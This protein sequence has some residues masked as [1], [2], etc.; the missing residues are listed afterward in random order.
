M[1]FTE[2]NGLQLR[3]FRYDFRHYFVKTSTRTNNQIQQIMKFMPTRR[4]SKI[5]LLFSQIQD[6]KQEIHDGLLAG[7][8]GK[9]Q[10]D[11]YVHQISEYSEEHFERF[12]LDKE[13]LYDHI[14]LLLHNNDLSDEIIEVL[15]E[16]PKQKLIVLDK[17][18]DN[19]NGEYACVYQDF[20]ADL[21]VALEELKI[22]LSKYK[23]L[24]LLIPADEIIPVGIEKGF[25][26]FCQE[27]A[28]KQQIHYG[29]L[30][31]GVCSQE[32]YITVN[33]Q[34]LADLLKIA[35]QKKLKIGSDFGVISYQENPL[36]EVLLGG[37][38]S[39][40]SDSFQ[41]GKT[42]AELLINQRREHIRNPFVLIQ[43]NSL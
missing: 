8:H 31:Q 37:I 25:L 12:V 35:I 11:M 40:S 13:P 24:N 18:C 43:R 3:I 38:T 36:K 32:A 22:G 20:E 34:D 17:R 41:L 29:L 28:F 16:I 42:A 23:K 6:F 39:L 19:I 10:V 9:A 14:A 7:T 30:P 27:N 26:R 15:N 1:L 2:D 33:E 21:T 4:K 5:L